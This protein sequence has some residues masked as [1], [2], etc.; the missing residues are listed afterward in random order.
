MAHILVPTDFSENAYNALFYAT[1]LYPNEECIITLLHSFEH[2]FSTNT[3]RIDIGR[4]EQLYNELEADS[5]K[6]LDTLKN[7]IILDSDG[8]SL[9]VNLMTGAQPLY[10][11]VNKCIINDTINV[12]VMGT[13]GTSGVKEV[14]LGTQTVKLINKVKPI[15]V[16]VVPQYATYATPTDIAY[17]T[18]LKIDYAQYPLEI[19]KELVRLHKS[20]LYITHI[21]NQMS[22]GET[23]E[24]NYRKLK[25][26]LEDVSYTTHWLSS[27]TKMEDALG[28]FIKEHDI[29]LL[30]LMYHKSGFLKKLFNKSFVDKVSFHSEIP[31]LI[32]PESF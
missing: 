11:M 4:N 14:F 1:R 7:K 13:K 30:V 31:L 6:K 32:L 25:H 12:V 29:N 19:I 23:V 9:V 27:T 3:S 17:A 2:L 16:V 26:K 10:K 28:V 21:Y 20:N 22:P 18:D 24:T 8:I 5:L 15:P